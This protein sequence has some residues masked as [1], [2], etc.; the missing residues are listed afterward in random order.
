MRMRVCVGGLCSLLLCFVLRVLFSKHSTTD[1][2]FF[3]ISQV[4]G[5]GEVGGMEV[6]RQ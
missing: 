1:Q 2:I 3:C 5:G 4:L 6:E